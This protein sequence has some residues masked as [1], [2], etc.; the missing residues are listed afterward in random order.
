MEK[1]KFKFLPR[2]AAQNA[3]QDNLVEFMQSMQTG[4][5]DERIIDFEDF[6][7]FGNIYESCTEII[8]N[9]DLLAN[10]DVK[11]RVH[12]FVSSTKTSNDLA[13]VAENID[14]VL[15]SLRS[16][17]SIFGNEGD[18]IK[19]QEA[20]KAWEDMN[21]E[22]ETLIKKLKTLI[23]TNLGKGYGN[24]QQLKTLEYKTF[25]DKTD[26]VQK[27][28]DSGKTV[29]EITE[30]LNLKYSLVE[31]FNSELLDKKLKENSAIIKVKLAENVSRLALAEEM[32]VT[33]T[34]LSKFITT[35]KLA[36]V[37]QPKAK[38]ATPAP[39]QVEN[40]QAKKPAKKAESAKPVKTVKKTEVVK[41]STSTEKTKISA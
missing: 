5:K 8:R 4:K 34:R 25:N 3:K 17:V 38:K 26:E 37:A 39:K 1:I 23:D 36:P 35:N 28:L 2:Y 7:L 14:G 30:K 6:F 20:A 12:T 18:F 22:T 9:K 13:Y 15:E 29:A 33:K 16:H 27:L 41:D 24:R 32:G 11:A 31:K 21:K 10:R 19:L 40:K